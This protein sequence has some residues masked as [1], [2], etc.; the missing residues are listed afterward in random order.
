MNC[1]TKNHKTSQNLIKTIHF[2]AMS[3]NFYTQS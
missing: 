3:K 2:M 1:K